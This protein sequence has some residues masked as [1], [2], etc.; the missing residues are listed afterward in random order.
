VEDIEL[1]KQKKLSSDNVKDLVLTGVNLVQETRD[2]LDVP[3]FRTIEDTGKRLQNGVFRA[4]KFRLRSISRYAYAKAYGY[5]RVPS[6][7]VLDEDLPLEGRLFNQ[8]ELAT[9]ATY[10]CAVHEVIHADDYTDNNRIVHET[11]QHITTQHENELTE[12]SR[13]LSRYSRGRWG[14]TTK[15]IVNTWAYQ[16]VDS[17]TH[18]RTY[19]VLKHKRF[20]KID[21]I[22]VSLYNSIFSPRLFTTIEHAK[23]LSYTA[24]LLSE[25]IGKTCIVE[26]VKEYEAASQRNVRTYTV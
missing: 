3:L 25:Q 19:L 13:I 20:P 26:L 23:G 6:T 11:L 8:P 18:Y 7:I 15:E 14:R 12:A 17:T 22:W 5:F 10:Y 4:R 16:Y 9:T 21:T 24:Y 1:L 2:E